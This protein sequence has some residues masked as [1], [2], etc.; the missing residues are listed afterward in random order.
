MLIDLAGWERTENGAG[1]TV[2]F[3]IG[4]V[5][6]VVN[7][8]GRELDVVLTHHVIDDTWDALPVEQNE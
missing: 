1:N 7:G 5:L 4:D 3:V 6:R 8:C 2:P